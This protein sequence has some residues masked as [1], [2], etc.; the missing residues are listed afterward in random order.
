MNEELSTRLTKE[1]DRIE[2][3]A[4]YS[5]KGHYY[6]AASLLKVHRWLGAL[7]A[8]F[9]ACATAAILKS[10]S[11]L[12]AVSFSV[13]AL[14]FTSIITFL[15]PGEASAHHQRSGD[16][17]LSIRNRARFFREIELEVP[18]K[19]ADELVLILKN[20]ESDMDAVRKAAPQVTSR[21]YAKAKHD[22][23]VLNSTLH[24]ADKSD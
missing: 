1:S 17:Y 5:A 4:E 16:S 20:I 22:I 9:S 3:D 6:S 8:V 12:V 24:R 11:S 18:S 14:I 13:M 10:W 7:S 15:K 23:E 19:A 2:E 21:G